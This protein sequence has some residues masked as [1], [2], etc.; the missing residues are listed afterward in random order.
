MGTLKIIV[1]PKSTQFMT[2]WSIFYEH[3]DGVA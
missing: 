3:N 2:S 1:K